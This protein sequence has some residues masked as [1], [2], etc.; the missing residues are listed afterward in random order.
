MQEQAMYHK[1]ETQYA[2]A[3]SEN[4][5]ALRLRTA[6]EDTPEVSV[7]L[8]RNFQFQD[9]DTVIAAAQM[10]NNFF[11]DSNSLY[12]DSSTGTY[13]LILHQNQTSPEDFNKVCNMLSEYSSPEKAE[14]SILAFLEEHCDI[15]VSADAVQKLSAL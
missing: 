14:P 5:V 7:S 8:M 12:K 15:I 3:L 9:L 13:S 4:S 6:K 2:Y 10:L 11:Q 1:P